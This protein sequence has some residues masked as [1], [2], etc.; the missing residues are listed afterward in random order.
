MKLV[1]CALLLFSPLAFAGLGGQCEYQG[2]TVRPT[3]A[4]AVVLPNSTGYR[5]ELIATVVAPDAAEGPVTLSEAEDG[6]AR[7]NIGIDAFDRV[8]QFR[9]VAGD[10]NYAASADSIGSYKPQRQ[11]AN[12][13]SGH[14]S[15]PGDGRTAPKCE[16][17]LDVEAVGADA[18]A[19]AAAPRPLE[20]GAASLA[21]DGGDPGR[22]YLAHLAALG[23]SDV[24]ALAA[25]LV[26]ARRRALLA[27]RNDPDFA[28]QLA[29][30]RR[31]APAT[32]IL[33][34]GHAT[35]ERAELAVEGHDP[36]GKRLHGIVWMA[37]EGGSWKVDSSNFRSE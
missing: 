17:D 36:D 8:V 22:A 27:H 32:A 37:K 33:H 5:L 15:L 16:L 4:R 1:A 28:R 7:I 26:D 18:E 24:D 12:R 14:F 6:S 9:Y 29:G 13:V 30:L 35:A 31:Q 20:P 3:D 10:R 25:T 19:V 23:G 34:G 2:G 21:A 11:A